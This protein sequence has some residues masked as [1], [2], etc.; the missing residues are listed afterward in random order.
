MVNLQELSRK[1]HWH[2]VKCVHICLL[3]MSSWWFQPIWKILVKLDHFPRVRVE[4]KKCLSCHHLDVLRKTRNKHT[5]QIGEFIDVW[6]YLGRD[7]FAKQRRHQKSSK[8]TKLTSH[9]KISKV[10]PPKFM[11]ISFPTV[12]GWNTTCT[13]WAWWFLSLFKGFLVGGFNP[14]EKY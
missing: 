7:Y 5:L 2:I 3:K 14:F 4:N 6:I 1:S 10:F 11:N 8:Q 9:K 13:S 12:D